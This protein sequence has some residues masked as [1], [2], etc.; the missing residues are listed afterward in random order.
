MVG[1]AGRVHQLYIGRQLCSP[2]TKLQQD[3]TDPY[4]TTPI[5]HCVYAKTLHRAVA[6]LKGTWN[7]RALRYYPRQCGPS[8]H[9]V[10]QRYP[11]LHHRAPGLAAKLPVCPLSCSALG[12]AQA[13]VKPNHVPSDVVSGMHNARHRAI[14]SVA[15][16][17]AVRGISQRNPHR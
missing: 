4:S 11:G 3:L 5:L 16:A 8:A 13:L 17:F 10:N 15:C 14:H 9:C 1:E 6:K 12:G 7:A 2:S